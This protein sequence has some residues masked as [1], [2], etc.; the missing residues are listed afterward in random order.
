MEDSRTYERFRRQLALKGFG[1]DAQERLRRA[2]ALVVGA[3][4]LGCPVLQYLAAAGVGHLG[5]A[6]PDRVGLSNLHRQVL[7]TEA[8]LGRHKVDVLRERLP[9]LNP[10]LRLETWATACDAAFALEAFPDHD[11]VIDTSDNFPTR[12][13]VND[14]CLLTGRPLVHAAV[15]EYE[16]QVAVFHLARV[17]GTPGLHYRHLFPSPPAPGEVSD[18]SEAGVLGV[19]PGIIG[20]MQALEAIKVLTGVG[21]PLRDRL[22]TYDTLR[23]RQL[24]VD[25]PAGAASEWDMPADADAYLRFDYGGFCGLAPHRDMEV[26]ISACHPGMRIIDVREFG[27][28]PPIGRPHERM[29]LSR[30]GELL[31]LA[32]GEEALF[33]CATGRR[34]RQAAVISRERFPQARAYSLKGGIQA[35]TAQNPLL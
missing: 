8:D 19:L 20:A 21:E 5:V 12:Y 13:L 1:P 30:L 33:V 16:G 34:S 31:R 28:T 6:D 25:I 15:S 27:E 35:L 9:G 22:L 3:G 10:D 29:P 24:V 18:C 23:H 7:Y 17:D 11:L 14:G 32:D 2:R 26:D 4:G